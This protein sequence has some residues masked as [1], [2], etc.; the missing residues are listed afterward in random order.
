MKN[1]VFLTFFLFSANLK[2]STYFGVGANVTYQED[3]S[4]EPAVRKPWSA[5]IGY[6]WN[7]LGL[8]AEFSWFTTVSGN[9]SL[10]LESQNRELLVWVRGSLSELGRSWIPYLGLGSG[11]YNQKI[12]TNL[13]NAGFETQSQVEFVL[14]AA[15]GIWKT[16]LSDFNFNL[17]SRLLLARNR[18][19][20][21]TLD[22]TF[23]LGY[24]F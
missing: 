6:K 9:Q 20:N 16:F 15:V 14:G 7:Q 11:I 17:E 13:N 19:P 21:P 5:S 22:I 1:L 24:F 3:A 12:V 10:N 4:S 2:A 18:T 23:K 8:L